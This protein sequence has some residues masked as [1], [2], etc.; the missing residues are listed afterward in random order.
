MGALILFFIMFLFSAS[1]FL[2]GILNIIIIIRSLELLNKI[3]LYKNN[4]IN[5]LEII[6]IIRSK[7]I[8]NYISYI[9]IFIDV[10][11]N[12]SYLSLIND[13]RMIGRPIVL[14]TINFLLIFITLVIV[15]KVNINKNQ[16]I[17]EYDLD[18]ENLDIDNKNN[19]PEKS[20]PYIRNNQLFINWNF[21]KEEIIERFEYLENIEF[22]N[23]EKIELIKINTPQS[24]QYIY[25]KNLEQSFH[26]L[27]LKYGKYKEKWNINDIRVNDNLME[28]FILLENNEEKLVKITKYIEV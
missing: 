7:I 11:I 16:I 3:N 28:F 18:V 8:S 25:A 13:L 26:I 5:E 2:L 9:V 6:K 19:L 14:S 4:K 1:M 20:L 15:L 17:K 10:L 12:I 22:F 27:L 23:Y 21:N 24:Q